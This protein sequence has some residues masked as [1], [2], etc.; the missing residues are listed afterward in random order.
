[1]KPWPSPLPSI[2]GTNTLILN[3]FIQYIFMYIYYFIISSKC[4][5][6]SKSK[7]FWK[8]VVFHWKRTFLLPSFNWFLKVVFRRMQHQLY[9]PTQEFTTNYAENV[10]SKII[11][12]KEYARTPWFG[13]CCCLRS[14][15]Q[16]KFHQCLS[17]QLAK[18]LPF[19]IT[20]YWL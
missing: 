10:I 4:F 8:W 11:N 19:Y 1:M 16:L 17:L 2:K 3:T 12:R 18:D 13:F 6:T 9:T 7:Q 5:Q 20:C 15:F 14:V